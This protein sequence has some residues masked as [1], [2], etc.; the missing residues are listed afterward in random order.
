MKIVIRVE[1]PYSLD[2][3]MKPSFLSSLYRKVDGWWV[4]KIGFLADSLRIKQ[5]G[6][7]LIAECD[8]ILSYKMLVDEVKLESG[9]WHHPF[10][11]DLDDLPRKF[12]DSIIFL[13][14]MYPGVRLA[15][16]P[17][18]FNFI[19]ISVLLSKRTKY[20]VFVKNWIT[21]LWSSFRCNF[22]VIVASSLRE[23]S[24]IGSSYQIFHLRRTLKDYLAFYGDEMVLDEPSCSLRR[25]LMRCW[26]VGPKV[27]DATLLFTK[28]EPKI[29]PVDVHLVRA[30]R[31]FNWT[32]NFKL[33]TK[34]L[35]LKYA[36]NENESKFLKLPIC[37]LSLRS[38]CLREQLIEIFGNLSGWVQTLTYLAGSKIRNCK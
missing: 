19:F 1:E 4:K 33:P 23:L 35:C 7:L 2:L 14:K 15:I 20:E 5:E 22:E 13:S 36:C 8:D 31:H 17:R 11:Y 10:E 29:L 27:A 32:D 25:K 18:D 3:T 24:T 16:S 9:L 34:S 28:Q 37:P 21:R 38:L 12:R 26:G 30:T 6:S